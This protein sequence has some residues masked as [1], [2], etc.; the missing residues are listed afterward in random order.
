VCD[1][2]QRIGPLRR[3]RSGRDRLR[4][5]VQVRRPVARLS[6]DTIP[7]TPA[8]G[9]CAGG[10]RA[11][12]PAARSGRLVPPRFR[13]TVA[14]AR[15]RP[16]QQERHANRAFPCHGCAA[17]RTGAIPGRGARYLRQA[18]P[19]CALGTVPRASLR[20]RPAIGA[21]AN[22]AQGARHAHGVRWLEGGRGGREGVVRNFPVAIHGREPGAPAVSGALRSAHG[23]YPRLKSMSRA[24]VGAAPTLACRMP[25]RHVSFCSRLGAGSRRGRAQSGICLKA[26]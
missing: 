5:L 17:G 25:M 18:D 14:R 7:G 19:A 8:I 9:R 3:V 13:R 26:C 15:F 20:T 22:R 2:L 16:P 6:C 1:R 12:R 23:L 24:Q 4:R 11:A 10:P 21:G